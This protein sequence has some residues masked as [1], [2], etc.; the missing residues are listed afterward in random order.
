[1]PLKRHSALQNLSRDHQ[2]FLLEARSMRWIANKDPRAP[3]LSSYIENFLIFW[4]YHGNPHIE[5]EETVLFPFCY[6]DPNALELMQLRIDHRLLRNRAQE[7]RQ[8]PDSVT[9]SLLR[10]LAEQIT[11]HV[12]HEERVVFEEIQQRLDEDQLAEL[13]RQSL[14]FR[15]EHR[16]PDAWGPSTDSELNS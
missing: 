11:E 15:K 6:S 14:A 8:N 16:P 9:P 5:E 3:E 2:L 1:M 13:G 12:R 7:I 10:E 4:D